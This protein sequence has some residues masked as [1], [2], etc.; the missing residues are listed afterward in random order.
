MASADNCADMLT[1][2]VTCA[3]MRR[4]MSY[5]A[6]HTVGDGVDAWRSVPQ[7]VIPS[8]PPSPPAAD[9]PAPDALAA[10]VPVP[11]AAHLCPVTPVA[12]APATSSILCSVL[13]Q[14][15]MVLSGVFDFADDVYESAP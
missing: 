2:P 12:A 7:P 3:E 1:R 10:L 5:I 14:V 8:P 9:E 15:G 4:L 6:P 13:A 11:M